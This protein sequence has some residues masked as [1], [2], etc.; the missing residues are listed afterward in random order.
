MSHV[1]NT[2]T[3]ARPLRTKPK[4]H[5]EDDWQHYQTLHTVHDHRHPVAAK[6]PCRPGIGQVGEYVAREAP[7]HMQMV[8]SEEDG[9]RDPVPP[10]E[11]APHLREQNPAKEQLFTQEVVEHPRDKEDPKQPPLP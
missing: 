4:D 1:L 9:V 8:E 3:T 7:R 2:P 6:A 11:R 10:P 5:H